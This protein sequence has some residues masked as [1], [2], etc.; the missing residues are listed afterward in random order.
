MHISIDLE[1]K[2]IVNQICIELYL[3]NNQNSNI[4]LTNVIVIYK[5]RR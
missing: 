5:K 3:K 2:I 1:L 4:Y